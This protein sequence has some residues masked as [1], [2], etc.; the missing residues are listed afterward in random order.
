VLQGVRSYQTASTLPLQY[1]YYY[2]YYYDD[3]DDDDD[4]DDLMLH[5]ET[6]AVCCQTLTVHAGTLCG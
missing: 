6:V 1:Y 3:D 4:D 5:M 2:Y